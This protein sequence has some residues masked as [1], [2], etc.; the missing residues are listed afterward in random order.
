MGRVTEAPAM[1]LP[2]GRGCASAI[3]S[4]KVPRSPCRAWGK[5]C[6]PCAIPPH[7]EKHHRTAVRHRTGFGPLAGTREACRTLRSPH[8]VPRLL[9][10]H[11]QPQLR[12]LRP[13]SKSP[14]LAGFFSPLPRSHV[15][16][17]SLPLRRSYCVRSPQ[18]SPRSCQRSRAASVPR[19]GAIPHPG[20][21]AVGR[22]LAPSPGP[23]QVSGSSPERRAAVTH[24]PPPAAAT[25]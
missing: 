18:V 13:L 12:A 6:S 1:P 14:C 7:V 9:W 21:G 10:Q 8:P 20:C 15:W 24:V 4:C 2:G 16:P 17:V 11:L 22:V 19:P 23:P 25:W 3:R 5:L